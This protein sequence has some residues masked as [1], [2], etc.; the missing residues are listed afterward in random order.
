[1]IDFKKISDLIKKT[2]EK[3]V[4]ATEEDFLVVMDMD[5]YEQ[6]LAGKTQ[7]TIVREMP[8]QKEVSSVF[9]EIEENDSLDSIPDFEANEDDDSKSRPISVSELIASKSR[10]LSGDYDQPA[11]TLEDNKGDEYFFEEID[12]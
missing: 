8:V 3:V 5:S 1:M 11:K 10:E 2:N 7:N 4:V 6:L 12:D 9:E